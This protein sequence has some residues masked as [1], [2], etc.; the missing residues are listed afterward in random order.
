[1]APKVG[2]WQTANGKVDDMELEKRSGSWGFFLTTSQP[3]LSCACVG[4]ECV[5]VWVERWHIE[6]GEAREEE[7]E[8]DWEGGGGERQGWSKS[9][10][11]HAEDC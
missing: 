2:W 1:M 8:E 3:L 11:L 10:V 7:E 9:G 5:G 4:A 6:T